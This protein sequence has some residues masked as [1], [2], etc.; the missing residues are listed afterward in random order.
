MACCQRFLMLW[1]PGCRDLLLLGWIFE[2]GHL[3]TVEIG[4]PRKNGSL[5]NG[6]VASYTKIARSRVR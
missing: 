5:K 6:G 1:A 3:F 2:L 4:A